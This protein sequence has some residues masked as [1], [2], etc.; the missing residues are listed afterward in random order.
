MADELFFATIPELNAKLKAREVSAVELTKLFSQ[1][2]ETWDP[3]Y[4]AL[5]LPLTKDALKRA[6]EV[7]GDIKRERFRGPLQGIP[8]G[9]KDLL[10]YAKY[11]DHLGREAI[12]RAGVRLHRDGAHEAGEERARC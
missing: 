2:L 9:A 1:R 4:N 11:P 12:C 5:A 3:R 8:F 6:K 10:S 7:D